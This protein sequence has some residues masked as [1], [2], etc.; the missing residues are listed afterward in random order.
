MSLAAGTMLGPYEM[1]APLC[2]GGR[3]EVSR[4]HDARFGLSAPLQS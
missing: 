1:L 3:G 2:A 4:A